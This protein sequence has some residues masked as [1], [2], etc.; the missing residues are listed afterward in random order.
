MSASNVAWVGARGARTF[1]LAV[2][3]GD[4]AGARAIAAR[5][6]ACLNCDA[7]TRARAPG[8]SEPSDWCGDPFV[9]TETSCGCL[10]A[11][12]IAVASEECPRR[13]W[14]A[15]RRA[16]GRWARRVTLLAEQM[17]NTQLKEATDGD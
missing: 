15:V 10:L 6:S 11:G 8:A 1:A 4:V 16:R 13:I 7:R 9:E 14:L 2:I 3:Q 17:M 12:K 5:R